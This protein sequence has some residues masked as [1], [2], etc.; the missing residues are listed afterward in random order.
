[1]TVPVSEFVASGCPYVVTDVAGRPPA[2]LDDF[3]GG[4]R[5]TAVR[6]SDRCGVAGFG[7]R[8]GT[9]VRFH[10]KASGTGRDLRVWQV[11][12]AGN[13]AFEATALSNY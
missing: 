7:S 8:V 13:N 12:S 4:S 1:M 3:V 2:D 11:S 10:E 5:F 6:G 9:V